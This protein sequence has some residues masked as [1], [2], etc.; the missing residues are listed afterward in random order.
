MVVIKDIDGKVL[1]EYPELDTLAGADLS[2]ENL[3]FADF[4]GM[5]LEGTRFEGAELYGAEF[6]DDVL[7]GSGMLDPPDFT[8]TYYEI[9]DSGAGAS[10]GNHSEFRGY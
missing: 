7:D 4:R 5:D 10:G 3:M 6:D 8:D 2:Y 9:V 1:K